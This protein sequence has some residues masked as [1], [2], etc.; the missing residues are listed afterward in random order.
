MKKAFILLMCTSVLGVAAFAY[1]P[2][3]KYV[4]N[5]I[6]SKIHRTQSPVSID[7]L[8]D[9]QLSHTYTGI[10]KGKYNGNMKVLIN[11]SDLVDVTSSPDSYDSTNLEEIVSVYEYVHSTNSNLPRKYILKE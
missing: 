9:Y 6:T 3:I 10:V 11:N 4:C 5:T 2:E 8:K 1:A 7:P